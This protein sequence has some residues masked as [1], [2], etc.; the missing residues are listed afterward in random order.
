MHVQD[1]RVFTRYERDSLCARISNY[2]Y[3]N[4]GKYKPFYL[5]K[6]FFGKRSVYS[7]RVEW[8]V[9]TREC[10]VSPRMNAKD[11]HL[12]PL[13]PGREKKWVMEMDQ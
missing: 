9:V 8:D 5:F 2:M 12:L 3:M 7:K 1:L 4:I 10:F 13:Q 11:W 6:R